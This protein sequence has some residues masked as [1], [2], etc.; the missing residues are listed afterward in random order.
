MKIG[1][2]CIHLQLKRNAKS[3]SVIAGI[4]S[5]PDL[6]GRYRKGGSSGISKLSQGFS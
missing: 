2:P 6:F 1:V 3:Y 5:G 4:L